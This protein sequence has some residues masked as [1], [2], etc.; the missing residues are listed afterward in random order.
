MTVARDHVVDDRRIGGLV[1]DV[2][3]LLVTA[4]VQGVVDD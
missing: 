2:D 4:T 1:A 3:A